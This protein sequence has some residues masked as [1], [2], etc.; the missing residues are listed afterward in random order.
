MDKYCS[1][2]LSYNTNFSVWECIIIIGV[3]VGVGRGGLG[4]T[5]SRF[6]DTFLVFRRMSIM[7]NLLSFNNKSLA[8]LGPVSLRG[9]YP[10]STNSP[11][12][13]T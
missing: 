8:D 13:L 6:S 7:L 9:L 2:L 5:R 12:Y 11:E 10:V 4:K 3:G 1:T